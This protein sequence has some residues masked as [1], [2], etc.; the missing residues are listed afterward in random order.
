MRVA[1]VGSALLGTI[2]V[3]AALLDLVALPANEARFAG[4]IATAI[5]RT[6]PVLGE[7]RLRSY[8]H[9]TDRV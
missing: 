6:P 2:A 8:T 5:V 7:P 9:N 1:G 4:H 3:S